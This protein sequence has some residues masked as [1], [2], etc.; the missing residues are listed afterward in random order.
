MNAVNLILEPQ[1]RL[2]WS[3]PVLAA[4][5]TH[6]VF[7]GWVIGSTPFPSPRPSP[8]GEGESSPAGRRILTP[9][10]FGSLCPAPPS[11]RG[12]GRGEGELGEAFENL[13]RFMMTTP[14]QWMTTVSLSF[15]FVLLF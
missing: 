10:V 14:V 2:R 3:A 13:G 6:L 8:Q 15:S 9:H 7:A 4:P 11:P 12:E 1:H 5:Y